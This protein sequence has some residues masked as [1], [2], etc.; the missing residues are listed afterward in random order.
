M[1]IT[2]AKIPS[3]GSG[4]LIS[5]FHRFFHIV[6]HNFFNQPHRPHSPLFQLK[7]DLNFQLKN[8]KNFMG[9]CGMGGEFP[10]NEGEKTHRKSIKKL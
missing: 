6:F 4:E 5:V 7:A 3:T 10:H 1:W 9:L 2:L 8:F